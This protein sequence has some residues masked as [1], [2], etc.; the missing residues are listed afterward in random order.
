MLH[1]MHQC[2]PVVSLGKRSCAGPLMS[3][4]LGHWRALSA[5]S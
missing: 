1:M 5:G 2:L 3:R 4:V